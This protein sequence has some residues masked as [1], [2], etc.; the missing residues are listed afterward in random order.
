MFEAL[1]LIYLCL[2]ITTHLPKQGVEGVKCCPRVCS[3]SKNQGFQEAR[4]QL[5]NICHWWCLSPLTLPEGVGGWVSSHT[6]FF[7]GCPESLSPFITPSLQ[8]KLGPQAF[9]LSSQFMFSPTAG[10]RDCQLPLALCLPACRCPLLLG[11]G[12][13]GNPYSNSPA[14]S[15]QATASLTSLYSSLGTRF[16]PLLHITC[17]DES[18]ALCCKPTFR[19]ISPRT[20]H[21]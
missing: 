21:S 14:L 8:L 13:Q 17:Q 11:A 15:W 16:R 20:R 4:L 6:T 9:T 5:A 7:W 19:Q 18:V 3:P 2:G 12:L 10:P 1:D